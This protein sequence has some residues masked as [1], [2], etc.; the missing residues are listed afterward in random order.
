[1]SDLETAIRQEMA[2]M[3]DEDLILALQNLKAKRSKASSPESRRAAYRKAAYEEDGVT[4]KQSWKEARKRAAD[5]RAAKQKALIAL[6][7]EKLGA[8]KVA[9]LGFR[10]S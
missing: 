6:A 1:M 8:A 2:N 3:T 10:V 7:V 9:E 5:K 4:I